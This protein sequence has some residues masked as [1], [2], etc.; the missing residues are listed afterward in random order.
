MLGSVKVQDLEADAKELL[1]CRED[2]TVE[3]NRW[4]TE[5]S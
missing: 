4:A 1:H 2:G 5:V 3:V